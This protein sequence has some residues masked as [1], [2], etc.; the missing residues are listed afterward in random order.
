[1]YHDHDQYES[2]VMLLVAR[3]ECVYIMGF[4]HELENGFS[5]T[6]ARG[7]T[8]LIAASW[9]GEDTVNSLSRRVPIPG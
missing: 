3:E 4:S 2:D 8:S 6:S 9:G 1:L 5:S 7:R